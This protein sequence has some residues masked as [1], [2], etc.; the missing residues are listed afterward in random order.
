MSFEVI[1]AEE[2]GTVGK[3]E[4]LLISKAEQEANLGII[5]KWIKLAELYYKQKERLSIYPW[6]D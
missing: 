1:I 2:N 5:G 6:P 4:D 3:F